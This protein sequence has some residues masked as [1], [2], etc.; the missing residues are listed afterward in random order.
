MKDKEKQIEEILEKVG[1]CY[2]MDV[3]GI[4]YIVNAHK[5]TPYLQPKLPEHSVVL[6]GEEYEKITKELAMIHSRREFY[7]I[8]SKETAEKIFN[9]AK[10]VVEKTKHIVDGKSYLH[11]DVLKSIIEQLGIEIKE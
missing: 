7:Q 8:G 2:G 10:E 4:S 6:S 1:I 3:A 5:L 9:K 11:I